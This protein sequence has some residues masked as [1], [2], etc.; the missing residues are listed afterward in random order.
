MGDP[1][2]DGKHV[3]GLINTLDKDGDGE[4]DYIEFAKQYGAGTTSKE[5]KKV[6]DRIAM[7]ETQGGPQRLVELDTYRERATD[8]RTTGLESRAALLKE[9]KRQSVQFARSKLKNI[10]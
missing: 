2:M 10:N 7:G 3:Q 9:R 6:I 1:N 5:L 4:I 8:K